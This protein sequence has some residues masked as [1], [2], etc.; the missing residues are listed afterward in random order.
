MQS[1][2]L[3]LNDHLSSQASVS[4]F[5]GIFSWCWYDSVE[6]GGVARQRVSTLQMPCDGSKLPWNNPL[7]AVFLAEVLYCTKKEAS[8]TG[9]DAA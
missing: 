9:A 3:L 6:R 2:A 7:V 4:F 8:L 5:A 1:F